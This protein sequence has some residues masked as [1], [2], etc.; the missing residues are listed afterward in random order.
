MGRPFPLQKKAWCEY[1][2]GD[3]IFLIAAAM[4]RVRQ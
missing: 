2:Y 1:M 3:G 4:D